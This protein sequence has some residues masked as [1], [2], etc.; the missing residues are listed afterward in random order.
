MLAALGVDV[1]PLV[2]VRAPR[3]LCSFRPWH[4]VDGADLRGHSA[5]EVSLM[6]GRSVPYEEAIAPREQ[7]QH[8][9]PLFR[10]IINSLPARHLPCLDSNATLSGQ[11]LC[12]GMGM[13]GSVGVCVGRHR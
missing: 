10:V 12:I 13:D 7:Q 4:T 6:A 5:A 9:D 8:W 11:F 1:V 3:T 2:G